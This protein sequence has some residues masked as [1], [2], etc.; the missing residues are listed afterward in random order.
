MDEWTAHYRASTSQLTH[1]TNIHAPGGIGTH[2]Q[3]SQV[4]LDI[5]VTPR[6]HWDWQLQYSGVT[7]LYAYHNLQQFSVLSSD[8][9][10]W[11]CRWTAC[12]IPYDLNCC[13]PYMQLDVYII[14]WVPYSAWWYTHTHSTAYLDGSNLDHMQS[15]LLFV[16]S[17]FK[18]KCN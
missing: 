11:W 16:Y 6:S 9:V 10:Y 7:N 13:H 18:H 12:L 3:S 14:C 17:T 8:Y 15:K 2:N 4:A 1:Q 5:Y